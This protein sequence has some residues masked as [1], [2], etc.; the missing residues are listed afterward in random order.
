[1]SAAVGCDHNASNNRVTGHSDQ[2][3]LEREKSAEEMI[4]REGG[5]DYLRKI[6]MFERRGT[7]S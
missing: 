2:H 4:D 6:K 7:G 5:Q 1:M 3:A